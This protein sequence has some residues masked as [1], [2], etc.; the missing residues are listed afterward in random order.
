MLPLFRNKYFLEEESKFV[1][2]SHPFRVPA[3][4]YCSPE[5]SAGAS[6]SGYFISGL[7]PEKNERATRGSDFIST[8]NVEEP[9]IFH[10]TLKSNDLQTKIS[11]RK[12]SF[13]RKGR[14]SLHEKELFTGKE[15]KFRTKNLPFTDIPCFPVTKNSPIRVKS[16]SA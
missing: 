4:F 8:E 15:Q 10:I 14:I 7:R 1:R 12:R 16:S 11:T 9:E 3:L 5:V 6:T 13:T 2:F